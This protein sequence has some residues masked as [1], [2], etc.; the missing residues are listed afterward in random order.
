LAENVSTGRNELRRPAGGVRLAEAIFENVNEGITVADCSVPGMPLIYVNKAFQ[1]LTGYKAEEVLGQNCRFLHA[2]ESD[3]PALE[4]VRASLRKGVS[5]TAVL[6]NCRKDG[7]LFYNELHLSPI[8]DDAGRI[9][10]FIGIQ[11]DVTERVNSEEAL[12]KLN[13][14]LVNVNKHLNEANAR[15]NELLYV[16]AHDIKSPLTSIMLS[17]ELFQEKLPLMSRPAQRKLLGQLE[18]TSR[19]LRDIVIDVLE[20][21]RVDSDDTRLK[22][23]PIDIAL[24]AKT[25]VR[26]YHEQIAAKRLRIRLL[27]TARLPRALADR[28]CTLAVI[29]NLISNAIKF[30]PPGGRI[31]VQVTQRGGF[32]RF[33]VKDAGAGI[34]PEEMPKLFGRFVKLSAQPTGGEHSTGLGLYIAKK[35]MDL[36]KGKIWAESEEGKGTKFVLEFRKAKRRRTT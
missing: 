19:H 16:A 4:L 14:D 2:G 15:L 33:E 32:I 34:K 9:V 5:C 35:Y 25:V 13:D 31:T 27:A 36:M 29:D 1:Q 23:E 28:N 11:R 30:S 20:A 6:R 18:M 17:L 10:Y 24:K 3:Q 26:F 12:W 22:R 8:R 21:R 7:S